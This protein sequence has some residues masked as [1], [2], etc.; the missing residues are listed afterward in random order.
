[1]SREAYAAGALDHNGCVYALKRDRPG[2]GR[3]WEIQVIVSTPDEPSARWLAENFGGNVSPQRRVRV[4]YHWKLHNAAAA[5]FLRAVRPWLI[6]KA[7]QADAA[8]ALRARI[9]GH[10]EVNAAEVAERDRLVL[11]LKGL[12]A[13]V[14][15]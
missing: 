3:S 14:P 15:A 2:K 7:S 11:L 9:D 13:Q 1:M 6:A 8:L 12:K 4:T 5:Q 10:Y